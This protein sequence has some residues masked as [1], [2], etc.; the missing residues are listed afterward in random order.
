MMMK[1]IKALVPPNFGWLQMKLDP[2]VMKRI[3][4][5]IKDHKKISHNHKLAGNITKSNLLEDKDNWLWSN[6]LYPCVTEYTHHF[7]ERVI[8]GVLTKDCRFVLNSLWVNFQKKY[9][10]NPVH[11]HGG[12]FSFVIWIKI[13]FD[14]KKEKNLPFVKHSNSVKA[15][16]FEFLYNDILG[17]LTTFNYTLDKSK[18]GDMLFFPAVLNHQ[19]YPFYTSDKER[20]SVS[21]NIS[22]NPEDIIR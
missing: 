21:G 12:V 15:A 8:N 1:D 4:K 3:N 14:Y 19:V 11:D 10:F 7:G 22:L 16:D 18:E 9:E 17:R 20:I 2:I 13:P 6:V 5:Y